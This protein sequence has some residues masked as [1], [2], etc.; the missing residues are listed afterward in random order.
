MLEHF[1]EVLSILFVII[2]PPGLI[3][4]FLGLTQHQSL[5]YKRL[6]AFK[7]CAVA[8]IV[9]MIFTFLGDVILDKLR[10]SEPAFRIAGGLLLLLTS[11]DMVVAHHLGFSAPTADEEAEARNRSDISVF[12]LGIPLIAGPGGMVSVIMLMRKIEGNHWLELNIVVAIS[13]V[14]IVTYLCLLFA[15]PISRLIGTTGANVLTRI[16]G[17]ILAAL[18]IQFIIN[19]F[20]DLMVVPFFKDFG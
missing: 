13:L 1:L 11:I 2:D 9:L 10:I 19:G 12:P 8:F 18:A 14:I 7:A 4:V 5:A 16:F 6:I 3:P 15:T 20:N 17:I